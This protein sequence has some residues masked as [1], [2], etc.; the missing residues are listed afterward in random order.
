MAGKRASTTSPAARKRARAPAA[1]P[2]NA[3]DAMRAA[4]EATAAAAPALWTNLGE[5][6]DELVPLDGKDAYAT[7]RSYLKHLE[8]LVY[9][10]A[11][12]VT[13]T[14]TLH[15]SACRV[16]QV[17]TLDR[18][19]GWETLGNCQGSRREDR[20]GLQKR[21]ACVDAISQACQKW[22]DARLQATERKPRLWR[23]ARAYAL[24]EQGR[25]D[26]LLTCLCV[27]ATAQTDAVRCTLIEDDHS[28]RANL[29]CRLAACSELEVEAFADAERLYV[30]ENVVF[31]SDD[32]DAYLSPGGIPPLRVARVT[33][34]VLLGDVLPPDE[35]LKTSGSKLEVIL[36][37]EGIELGLVEEPLVK[38]APIASNDNLADVLKSATQTEVVRAP[39]P[40]ETHEEDAKPYSKDNEL[41]YLS[42]LFEV[43]AL[44]VRLAS[45]TIKGAI[46]ES[47]GTTKSY[48]YGAGEEGNK[49]GARELKAKLR[50]AQTKVS[51]RCVVTPKRPRLLQL[52]T[53][54]GLDEWETKVVALLVGRTISPA[55][56]SLMDGMESGSAVQRLDD[57]TT[58]GALLAIF[59]P[60][61]FADQVSHRRRF[62]KG[63]TLV[64]R[65]VVRLQR[66]RWHS[67][68][69]ADLTEQR[70]ELDRRVLDFV[71]GL[72]TEID[73]LVEG[74]ELYAPTTHLEDVVL[75]K[76]QKAQLMELCGAFFNLAA[77]AKRTGLFERAVPYG[78]GFVVLLCG[79]SGTGK[80]MTVHGV[81]RELKKRV[82]QV[83]FA[84]L[85]GKHHQGG[86]DVDADLRGL[87]REAEMSDAVLFFDECEGLFRTRESGGDRLLRAMLQEIEKC[88]GLV[89]LA[90]N[91]PAE[92][93]QA[94]HRR[95][96]TVVE[97]A[98]PGS[99][100]RKAIWKSLVLKGKV[101]S[102][103][104]VD[105]D[106]VALKYEL[107]GGFIKNALLAAVLFALARDKTEPVV[108]EADVRRGC[109]LQQ[110]GAMH[111][112]HACLGVKDEESDATF[113]NLALRPDCRREFEALVVFEQ[114][115]GV[116]YGQW[117]FAE[118]KAPSATICLLYGPRGSGKRTCCAALA[119][120]LGRRTYDVDARET[121]CDEAKKSEPRLQAALDDARLSDAIPVLDG[122]ENAFVPSDGVLDCAPG[123][124]RALDKL[125]RFP[126]PVL[127]VAHVEDVR[128]VRLA[129]QLCR[130]LRFSMPIGAPDAKLR[131]AIWRRALPPSVPLSDDVDLS[132][133][134]RRHELLPASIGRAVLDGAA[135]AAARG[136]GTVVHKDLDAAAA[137]EAKRL[138]GDHADALDR[139][140]V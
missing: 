123:L 24:E 126:G 5:F 124:A 113:A 89:F 104:S 140:F 26:R 13:L 121:L 68:G 34:R 17:E 52:A 35:L 61:G 117:G 122:F 4:S 76:K 84:S 125:A 90:T 42:E 115:R 127:L 96:S 50:V 97:Y 120:A 56:K 93:D 78:N 57:S 63:A 40:P 79:P 39:S 74:S 60:E 25:D 72:D 28:R 55:V 133:L 108:N 19:T 103:E 111:K 77:H 138:R 92:L 15:D 45:A 18:G 10:R 29:L 91:R 37:E 118:H 2:A 30:K 131:A 43:V 109:A 48:Y 114:Q 9:L 36:K 95:I 130:R 102:D 22:R 33:A 106:A 21:L 32:A 1:A 81:A 128:G 82:L 44:H 87:F 116:V 64:R 11:L 53:K 20:D 136:G 3:A 88:K 139:L 7:E 67:S 23:L 112:H 101:A 75:P 41:E 85:R 38:P 27:V 107:S 73:E 100:Q 49:A 46:K 134:G 119:Q 62:Y 70:V 110:R 66:S 132:T 12:R 16:D 94:M 137:R 59:C 80:T 47:S 58:V 6:R 8:L 14:A 54:L 129:P 105:W 31:V 71:V 135:R 86:D 83:D 69:S 51:R 98:P 65:G 99:S